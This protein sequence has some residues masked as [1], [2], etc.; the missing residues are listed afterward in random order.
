M[1]KPV[2][3]ALLL[4]LLPWCSQAQ[5]TPAAQTVPTLQA[6]RAA[7]PGATV[8]VSGVVSNGAELGALRFVQD[9]TGGLAA[10]SLVNLEFATLSAGDSVRLTGTLQNQNGLLQMDPVTTVRILAGNRRVPVLEVP[11]ANMAAAFVEA[12]E[13]RLLK[14]KGVKSLTTESG[15]PASSL[16]GNF[17]YLLNGQAATPLRVSMT[18]T[19]EGGLLDKTAPAE[20]FDVTGVLGQSTTT[21]EGGYVLLPRRAADVVA[22]GG[23]PVIQ[24]EPVPTGLSRTGFTVH[25]T[26]RSPGTAKVEY[27]KTEALGSVITLDTPATTH[28]VALADL[29]PG[30]LYYVKVSATNAAGTATAPAVPMITD[31]TKKKGR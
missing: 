9:A 16:A 2:L 21:G 6:A 4:G 28:N 20:S 1:H 19:G 8:T 27:G 29:E 25:F 17:T 15:A 10:Y 30:T 3:L 24:G 31:S 22:G 7:G 26:T 12:N 23:L 11:A 5:T 18:S 14:I 13:G